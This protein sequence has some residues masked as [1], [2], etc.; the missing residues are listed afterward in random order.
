MAYS[1]GSGLTHLRLTSQGFLGTEREEQQED[2]MVAENE[3]GSDLGVSAIAFLM[4]CSSGS[5]T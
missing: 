2:T 5:E 3:L 4:F 1:P